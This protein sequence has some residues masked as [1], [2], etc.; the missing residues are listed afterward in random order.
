MEH[1]RAFAEAAEASGAV[2]VPARVLDLG[3]GGGVPALVLAVRWKTS[4][5]V[6]V[7]SRA[8]RSAFLARAVGEL[9]LRERV[10]VL[11]ERAEI[12]GRTPGRRGAFDLV[13][14]RSFAAPPVVAECAAPFLEVGGLLIVS[15]PPEETGGVSRRWPGE[16]LA[17]LGLGGAETVTSSFRFVVVRQQQPC[18]PR[19]PRR[20]GVPA[21]RPIF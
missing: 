10:T 9:G 12:V 14:A 17:V 15:E 1:A 4:G 16:G 19:F 11:G 5:F 20:V 21:K 2:S 6:L 18:P 3:S 8:R 7:E 13:T